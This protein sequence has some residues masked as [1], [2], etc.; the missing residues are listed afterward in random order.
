MNLS[1]NG[2]GCEIIAKGTGTMN[3]YI[4]GRQVR[5]RTYLADS[6]RNKLLLDTQ[7]HYSK[8]YPLFKVLTVGTA[9][10]FGAALVIMSLKK[11]T[12]RKKTIKLQKKEIKR[13]QKL[14]PKA[15]TDL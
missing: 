12:E 10:I 14:C 8:E 4:L 9:A 3:R 6:S 2:Y 13:L 7:N 5:S 11:S 15:S 1:E